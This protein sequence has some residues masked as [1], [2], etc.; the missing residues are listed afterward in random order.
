M[1]NIGFA[2]S[3]VKQL[4]TKNILLVGEAD[5]ERF[6]WFDRDLDLDDLESLLPDLDL[7]PDLDLLTDA[8]FGLEAL[9]DRDLEFRGETFPS[10]CCGECERDLEREPLRSDSIDG[11]LDL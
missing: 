4:L 8:L 1:V 6:E 10:I 7:E 5:P 9:R 2:G 11:D 3:F